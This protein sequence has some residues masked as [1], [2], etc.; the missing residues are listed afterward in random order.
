MCGSIK[1]WASKLFGLALVFGLIVSN[2]RHITFAQSITSP[3]YKVSLGFVD[4]IRWS[5]DGHSLVFQDLT[6]GNGLETDQESWVEYDVATKQISRSKRWPLQPTLTATQI[7]NFEMAT[8][9][10]SGQLTFAFISPDSRFMVYGATPPMDWYS[11][12]AGWPIGIADLKTGEHLV[13]DMPTYR[14]SGINYYFVVKWSKMSNAFT[15]TTVTG[16]TATHI[17]YFTG[18]ANGV[19]KTS[20]KEISEGLSV[21]GRSIEPYDVYDISADGTKLLLNARNPLLW[22]MSTG[23]GKTI[24]GK[25][26]LFAASF[27]PGSDKQFLFMDTASISSVDADSLTESLNLKATS[28]FKSLGR[29]GGAIFS[30][31][32]KMSALI[33]IDTKLNQSAIYVLPID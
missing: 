28:N 24:S 11:S 14:L 17:Y 9:T 6:L 4:S 29:I 32:T 12:H 26:Q 22:D 21:D 27:S 33:Q 3:I 25:N 5:N 13:T 19:T 18:F 31:D 30:P 8:D 2:S 1:R 16:Y 20:A 10:K 15:V 7:Q 23:K